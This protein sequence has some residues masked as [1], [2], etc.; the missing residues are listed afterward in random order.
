MNLKKT[1][2]VGR[3][4]SELVTNEGQ[5]S[6]RYGD[7]RIQFL[8]VDRKPGLKSKK[9]TVKVL[10]DGFV[11]VVA[12]KSVNDQEL[13]GIVRK[14]GAWILGQL[15]DGEAEANNDRLAYV[16]GST[17]RYLGSQY[18]LKVTVGKYEQE[19][20]KLRRGHFEVRVN[21]SQPSR[22]ET[23][24]KRWYEVKAREV[25]ERRLEACLQQT[26]WVEKC[27]SIRLMWMEKQWGNCSPEGNLTLNID[28]V[29]ASSLC[30]DYVLLHELCHIAE[31][32]HSDR[33]YKLLS[34]V[35]PNWMDVKER[36]DVYA[37]SW[38]NEINP[39]LGPFDSTHNKD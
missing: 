28:L 24:L 31:H 20:V 10:P 27:P 5:L 14:R 3:E 15:K 25:F 36:L 12:P 23:A 7:H 17:H 38:I 11:E 21:Y 13:V 4:H 39:L 30:I 32:N 35:M 33:F 29:K 19:S 18:L 2:T 37:D 8:R 26:P 16:S 6:F 9:V 1:S 22:V 34:Q